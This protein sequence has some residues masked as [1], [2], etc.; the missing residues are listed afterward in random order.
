MLEEHTIFLYVQEQSPQ[1]CRYVV[2]TEPQP[3]LQLE[4]KCIGVRGLNYKKEQLFRV[5]LARS[6]KD[7]SFFNPRERMLLRRAI[8]EALGQHLKT[9]V[10][11]SSSVIQLDGTAQ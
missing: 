10:S 9:R 3:F 5:E 2:S 1:R 7:W 8:K 11:I 4:F 6:T